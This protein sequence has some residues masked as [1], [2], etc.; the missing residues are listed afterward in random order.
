MCDTLCAL[1]PKTVG[2][3]TLF[4]KNSDR[5]PNEPHLVI[6]CKEQEYKKDSEVKLTYITIPQAEHTLEVILCKPSW[7][8]GAEMGVN[9]ASVA[10]GNEAV[11]TK[12]KHGPA[13]LTGMDLVR[14]ALER[15]ANA[16]QAVSCITELLERYGQGGNCGYDHEFY[17]DNSFLIADPQEGYVVE[18]SGK[19]WVV[20]QFTN[21]EAI[22]NRLSIRKEHTLRG[23][24]QEAY[25]FTGRLTEPVYTYFSGSAK[26]RASSLDSLCSSVDEAGMMAA[27]RRHHPEDGD[28]VF[29][30]GSVR[31]VC[32]HAGGIVGDHTTGSLVV[33]LRV[34]MPAT[35]WCTAASTPCISAFKPVFFTG[36]AIAPVFDE[37]AE[38]KRYWLERET[39]HRGVL[40]GKVDLKAF[41]DKRDN[42]ENRWLIEERELFADG[43]PDSVTLNSFAERAAR[44][45]QELI[46]EY[47][48]DDYILSG[49]K[50]FDR[51]WIQKNQALE[52]A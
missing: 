46:T 26:R 30:H 18:T 15:S 27:L 38:A 41:Q 47:I 28:R 12:A 10:I 37:E 51:Y 43:V 39:I 42:L 21:S 8:W 24:V 2:G 34:D 9:S 16:R 17:Y 19:K 33:K 50:R 35:L 36:G 29:T 40:A 22:S 14:L 49:K 31:S 6:R 48:P 1:Q 13:A 52:K 20:K 44:E 5:S 3:S 45:E 7:T 11:F 32:M 25:D 23:G 4:A